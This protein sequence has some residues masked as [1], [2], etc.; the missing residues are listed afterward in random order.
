MFWQSGILAASVLEAIQKEGDCTCRFWDAGDGVYPGCGGDRKPLRQR[1]IAQF[2]DCVCDIAIYPWW[3]PFRRRAIALDGI[4][5]MKGVG[6]RVLEGFC[7]ESDC[8]IISF[9]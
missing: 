2:S 1:A 3:K 9:K 8:I 6:A 4:A 5:A 7:V